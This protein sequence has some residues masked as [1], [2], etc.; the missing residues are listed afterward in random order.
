MNE[1][2]HIGGRLTRA[3]A[4]EMYEKFHHRQKFKSP[5]EFLEWLE[6]QVSNGRA[7]FHSVPVD[8]ESRMGKWLKEQKIEFIW[9]DTNRMHRGSFTDPITLSQTYN[10][11]TYALSAGEV[12]IT[13]A[14]LNEFRQHQKVLQQMYRYLTEARHLSNLEII[15]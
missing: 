5:E 11:H 1:M 10:V 4:V 2:L 7:E 15:A 12:V 14:V 6:L 13:P 8:T 9:F 3:A